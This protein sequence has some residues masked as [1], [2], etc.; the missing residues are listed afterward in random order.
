VGNRSRSKTGV[1][2]YGTV[3]DRPDLV[4]GRNNGNI[5]SGTTAGCSGVAAGRTLG[6]PNLYFDPCAFTL[7][8]VGFLGNAGRNFLRGPGLANLDFSLVKDTPVRYLGEGGKLEFRAEFFN[9]LNRANFALPASLVFAGGTT[10]VDE[11]RLS[12]AG[13]ITSTSTTSRQI[14]LALKLLF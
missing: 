7:Q 5:I 11:P 3:N 13:L 1:G 4:S 9:I 6:T 2:G 8:P 12:T 10:T 14:Q